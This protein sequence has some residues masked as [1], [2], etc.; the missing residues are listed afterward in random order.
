[1]KTSS[2]AL[3]HQFVS[4]LMLMR[5]EAVSTFSLAINEPVAV[6]WQICTMCSITAILLQIPP[7]AKVPTNS[8]QQ[9]IQDPLSDFKHCFCLF[10]E[11]TV[12]CWF[13]WPKHFMCLRQTSDVHRPTSNVQQKKHS[14]L[15]TSDIVKRPHSPSGTAVIPVSAI[16]ARRQSLVT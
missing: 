1:M 13:T 3:P 7:L 10:T 15:Q 14:R 2:V 5:L 12:S 16:R 11:S 9:Q 6:E 4:R 8:G